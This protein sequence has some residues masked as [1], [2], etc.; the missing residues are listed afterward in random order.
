MLTPFQTRQDVA[1]HPSNHTPYQWLNITQVCSDWRS[2]ALKSRALWSLIETT[3]KVEWVKCLL[4]R[5]FPA[6]LTVRFH[7]YGR[8]SLDESLRWALK[9]LHRIV[10]VDL[11]DCRNSIN[12]QLPQIFNQS[13]PLL[14]S[15]SL[16]YAIGPLLG[17]GPVLSSLELPSLTH[18]HVSGYGPNTCRSLFQPTMTHLYLTDLSDM[19]WSTFFA[20]LQQMRSLVVLEVDNSLPRAESWQ[21][22]TLY[23]LPRLSHL[24]LLA[25]RDSPDETQLFLGQLQFPTVV[26]VKLDCSWNSCFEAP[27]CP[28]PYPTKPEHL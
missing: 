18:L 10:K 14:T 3:T 21:G 15:I 26:S 13:A 23:P 22:Q 8:D 9:A 1:W 12:S 19:G 2:V 16:T 17:S 24:Q 7:C 5:S 27:M 6:P 4:S 25:I 28:H 11:R 20:H